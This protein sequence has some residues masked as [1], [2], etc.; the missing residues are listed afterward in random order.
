MASPLKALS[1]AAVLMLLLAAA[2][3][4]NFGESH[5]QQNGGKHRGRRH[6]HRHNKPWVPHHKGHQHKRKPV[7][8]QPQPVQPQPHPAQ[9]VEPVQQQPQPVQPQPVQP[10]PVQPQPQLQPQPVQP[11]PVEHLPPVLP[12]VPVA[13]PTH[14]ELSSA[15]RE[16]H[17]H[18]FKP[19]PWK[20][21]HATFYTGDTGSFGGACGYS[22]VTREGYGEG[23]T[24]LSTTLF[25]NGAA[26]GACFE[27]K[28]IDDPKSC[29]PGQPSLFVTAT[30]FC[31]PNF[32]Q[33]TNDGGWCNPPREHF[34]IAYPAFKHIAEYKAGIV[35]VAYRR[36][37]CKKQGGIKFTITGTKHWTLVT[38]WN[39]GGAGDISHVE[40]KGDNKL[41][42][43][44]LHKNWGSKWQTS[45]SLE[46]ESLTFKVTTS[47]GRF[48]ISPNVTPN[49]YWKYGQTFEGLNFR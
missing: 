10:Q 40:V 22:D 19:G 27:I 44:P 31:P 18:D 28:C 23:T 25:H 46:E 11:M 9:P 34:D 33:D 14:P 36:V 47:D 5:Q 41:N 7:H 13:K 43:T 4:P 17:E 32:D 12:G 49:K 38:I 2:T 26:C 45:C 21:A 15:D 29:I 24:A 16:A 3:L 1:S 48:V 30:N 39:I 20:H 35:P 37:S 8:E 6:H 42:W